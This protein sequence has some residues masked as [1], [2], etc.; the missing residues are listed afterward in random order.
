MA[1]FPRSSRSSWDVMLLRR[2]RCVFSGDSKDFTCVLSS[3]AFCLKVNVFIFELLIS[4]ANVHPSGKVLT[5]LIFVSRYLDWD[6]L[7]RKFSSG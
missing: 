1:G 7:V 5:G 6:L 4:G 3:L 2:A